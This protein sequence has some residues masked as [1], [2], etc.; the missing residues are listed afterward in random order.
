MPIKPH[1][2]Q[3]IVGHPLYL[4]G[5]NVTVNYRLCSKSNLI[6]MLLTAK[7]G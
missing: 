7:A 4:L 3:L 6:L 1:F 2:D 5:G